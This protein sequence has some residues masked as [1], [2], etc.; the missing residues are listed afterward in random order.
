MKLNYSTP[1]LQISLNSEDDVISTSGGADIPNRAY[2]A[3][4]E[5]GVAE[6]LEDYAGQ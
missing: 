5:R 1:L 4:G 3:P 2:F 6:K